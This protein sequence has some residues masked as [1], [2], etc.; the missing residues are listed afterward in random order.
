MTSRL[1]Y[2]CPTVE[3]FSYVNTLIYIAADH[4]IENVL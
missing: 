1:P 2:W 4:V 3:L